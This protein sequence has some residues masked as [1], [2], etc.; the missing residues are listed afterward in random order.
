MADR[1]GPTSRQN[2]R[3][4]EPATSAGRTPTGSSKRR[5][6]IAIL[7]VMLALLGAIAAWF[8]YVHPVPEPYF[9]AIWIDEYRDTRIPV[10]AWADRD[11]TAL[12]GVRWQETNAFTRQER[13]LL[14]GELSGL[15]TKG[16]RPIVMYLS[17]HALT[18]DNGEILL[19]PGDASADDC[20]YYACVGVT[21]G[22]RHHCQSTIR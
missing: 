12:R 13:H 10:N 18:G 22:C 1:L 19:L 8:F 2:W 3:A 9:E 17:A 5:Q 7:F 4:G 6:I 11:R 15:K 20:Q 21:F 16:D 14:Q